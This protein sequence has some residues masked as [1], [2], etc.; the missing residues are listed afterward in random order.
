MTHPPLPNS[1]VSVIGLGLM[2]L[3]IATNLVSAG[4]RVSG[5]DP[6]S[7]AT[8]RAGAAGIVISTDAVQAAANADVVLTSLPDEKALEDTVQGFV[9]HCHRLARSPVIVELSTLSV[10][11]KSKQRDALAKVGLIMLDCPISGTGAQAISR[12]IAIYASGDESAYHACAHIF[13]AFA[14]KTAFLGAFG[15][16]MKMKLVANL[17][18]A[19]HNV[20]TAEAINLGARAG[21]DPAVIYDVIKAGAGTSRV[22]ELRGPMMV[23]NSFEPATMKLDVWKKDLNLI[24]EFAALLNVQTPLFSATTPLYEAALRQVGGQADTAA[25]Y[26]VLSTNSNAT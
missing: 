19:V 5:F 1:C 15:A 18:V 6:S 11:A 8:A 20:A 23:R 13:D 9:Q 16:G 17:L 3:P 7:T 10:A 14:R 22:F 4:Y 26:S 12:D 24:A 25:V 21:L 2:G